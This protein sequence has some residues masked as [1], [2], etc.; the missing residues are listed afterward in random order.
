MKMQLLYEFVQ[1]AESL[2]FS[3][4]ALKMNV[5]QPVL[6]RHMKMLEEHFETELLARNTHTV[7]LT[8]AGKLLLVEARK[9]IQQYE[10]S[11]STVNA[12]T[13]K[14]RRRLSVVFLGEAIQNFLI[15]FL[16]QFRQDHTDIAVECHDCELDEALELLDGHNCDLGL[17]IRPGFTG[18]SRFNILP[19][20]TDPLC[21]AV[22]RHHPLAGRG[23]VSLR[24]VGAWPLIRI[25]PREFSLSEEYSTRFFDIHGIPFRVGREYA[26]LKTCCFN[27][28]FD[29]QSVM[30][31]PKHRRNWLGKNCVLLDLAEEDCKFN[32][33][34][35]WDDN[36]INPCIAV[37][38]SA[39]K[40]FLND[41]N[42][43]F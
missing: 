35:V 15:T 40:P 19:L 20:T 12:F 5:T 32:V 27:L 18:N 30:L 37:F 4:A 31:M 14:S 11:L 43:V 3:R 26:N 33:E 1:L 28:E 17:L 42:V 21:V 25:N 39:L 29:T 22:N 23:Q 8:S 9:I 41:K 7:A 16:T 10:C 13:G 2:N 34:L 24:E 38:L 6:S 36:N